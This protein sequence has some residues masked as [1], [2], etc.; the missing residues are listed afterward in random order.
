MFVLALTGLAVGI[1][2]LTRASVL[3][4]A[5]LP[6]WIQ[7]RWA[8]H[9]KERSPGRKKYGYARYGNIRQGD[10]V[11]IAT[12]IQ[13]VATQLGAQQEQQQR[14]DRARSCREKITLSAAIAA[15]LFAFWSAW[16]FNLQLSE[17]RSEQRPWIKVEPETI[18]G[19]SIINMGPQAP[20]ITLDVTYKLTNVGHSPAFNVGL[21]WWGFVP[22]G[23]HDDIVAE[24]KTRC[25][26]YRRSHLDNPARGNILFP[27]D[28][29]LDTALVMGIGHAVASA[30]GPFPPSAFTNRDGK[31]YIR[32]SIYGCADYGIVSGSTERHQT[33]SIYFVG[34]VVQT[35]GAKGVSLDFDIM[36]NLP[37]EEVRLLPFPSGSGQTD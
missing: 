22:Y 37:G 19:L 34:H 6:E 35:N 27:G 14:Q 2:A 31:K 9:I 3:L 32:F 4:E 16:I 17:M 10:G 20:L 8:E 28:R 30:V 5:H 7:Q 29:I 18:N 23:G 36:E 33:G 11:A 13:A 21:T 25:E 12:R 15:A 26:A 24:Q 1:I